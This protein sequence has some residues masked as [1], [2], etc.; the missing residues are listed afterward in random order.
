MSSVIAPGPLHARSVWLDQ[1]VDL[2]TVA[3]A[4]GWLWEREGEGFA[5]P[6]RGDAHHRARRDRIGGRRRRRR[7]RRHPDRRRGRSS[8]LRSGRGRRAAVGPRRTGGAVRAVDRRRPDRLGPVLAHDDRRRPRRADRARGTGR[9]RRVGIPT[10][11]PCR[12]LSRTTSGCASSSERCGP[13]TTGGSSKSSSRARCSPRPTAPSTCRP[14]YAGC[15]RSTRRAPWWVR[16]SRGRAVRRRQPRGAR[17]PRRRPRAGP[18]RSRAR[19]LAAAIPTPTRRWPTASWPRRRTAPSTRGSCATSSTASGRG[20]RSSTSRPHHRS[21]RCAT[22]A[23]SARWSRA[24]WRR[25]SPSALG[26]AAA[27]HPTA[28]VGGTPRA[29][30]L[31][32]LGAHEGLDRGPYAGPVGWVDGRG[33]GQWVVGIRCG[34]IRDRTARLF[35]GVGV[36]DGLRPGGRAGRDAVQAP[37]AAGGGGPALTPS[38]PRLS[39]GARATAVTSSSCTA[40]L[41]ARSV[42]TWTRWTPPARPGPVERG[43]SARRP[44]RRRRSGSRGR[45][46]GRTGR[47][48]VGSPTTARTA[49]RA[50]AA[51]GR[52]PK[53]P[54]P[55]LSTT[56]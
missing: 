52:K 43:R 11:S 40:R 41:A 26:L 16:R 31:E 12:R 44:D 20:A 13:S 49:R 28:A 23:I 15:A 54:P 39:R 5:G 6:R 24:P 4:D 33:D 35:A 10:G 3:G 9:W 55:S 14:C 29:A 37:G 2:L 18:I 53:I 47:C 8:R 17:R 51:W 27:L 19:S 30:A 32:W 21:S 36:V 34:V 45:R 50:S 42:R 38:S 22:S 7:A 46:R 48:R 56:T 25:R 1:S